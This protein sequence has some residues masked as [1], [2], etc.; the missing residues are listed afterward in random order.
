MGEMT[1][2]YKLPVAKPEGRWQLGKFG[3]VLHWIIK[4]DVE[5]IKRDDVEWINL[6][7]DTNQYRTLS[8]ALM[9]IQ[10]L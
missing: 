3:R 8:I 6:Y 1:D 5:E 10:V 7:Q 2:S 9:N 4:I